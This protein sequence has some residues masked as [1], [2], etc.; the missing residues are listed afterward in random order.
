MISNI[1][2]R[3]TQSYS[4]GFGPSKHKKTVVTIEG[5]PG[6]GK[7][8]TVFVMG[9]ALGLPV[10]QVSVQTPTEF[11]GSKTDPGDFLRSLARKGMPRNAILLFDDVDHV[12]NEGISHKDTGNILLGKV[13]NAFKAATARWLH[14]FDPKKK[15]FYS[16]YLDSE[17]DVSHFLFALTCN[18]E[19]QN[20][21]LKDRNTKVTVLGIDPDQKRKNVFQRV[22]PPILK[23]YGLSQKDLSEVD[24]NTIKSIITNSGEQSYRQI[25]EYL[26]FWGSEKS[27]GK[28]DI[29]KGANPYGSKLSN[30]K[31]KKEKKEKVH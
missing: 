28:K 12:L 14:L 7:T 26:E 21:A 25:E 20:K 9:E 19:I 2:R 27:G 22:L 17:V 10:I 31:E 5:K 1:A 23:K 11:F 16:P 8:E 4:Q 29:L 18:S 15:S 6:L 3:H 30:K 13:K 24:R